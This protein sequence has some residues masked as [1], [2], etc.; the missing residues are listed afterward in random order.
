MILMYFYYLLTIKF[1]CVKEVGVNSI[2]LVN[3]AKK[4]M[5]YVPFRIIQL[6]K[7]SY[8]IAIKTVVSRF[9]FRLFYDKL[10]MKKVVSPKLCKLASLESLQLVYCEVQLCQFWD[11]AFL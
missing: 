3:K 1:V 2:N 10:N 6:L 7:K 11:Y 8:F 4:K 9:Y 5:I